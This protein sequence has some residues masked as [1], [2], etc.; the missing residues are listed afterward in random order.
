MRCD[1]PVTILLVLLSM[2]LVAGLVTAQPTARH[3]DVTKATGPITI[4]GRLDEAAWQGALEFDIPYEWNPGDNA[5]A[6][7]ETGVYITYSDEALYVAWRCEDPDPSAIRAHLMDRD[8]IGTFVQDDHV[9]LIIDTFNDERRGFQF[10]VNPLGVQADAFFSENEGIEDFSFDMIWDSV[11]RI[12]ETGYVVEIAIPFDQIRFP[13]SS[14]PQTWGFDVG[15]SYPRNVRHRLSAAPRDRNNG[16]ILCQVDKVSGFTGLEPGRNLEIIPTLTAGRTD[17]LDGFPDGDLVSGDEDYELGVDARWGINPNLTLS[18]AIN[19]DFSQ[20]EADAAQLDVNTRFALFFPERRPFFLEGI[21]VF[22]TPMRAVFTRTVVDP[23]W[24]L[25]LSGKEGPHSFGVFVA[26]DTVNNLLIPANERS[27]F[28]SVDDSV[29]S[30]VL[31]YRRDVGRNSSVGALYAGREGSAY[32]NDVY[33]VDGFFRLSDSDT[34]RFQALRSDTEYPTAVADGLGQSRDGF[35]GEAIFLDYDH[36]SR[37][38]NA[39]LFHQQLSPE[40]RADSGFIPKVDFKVWRAFV[41]RLFWGEEGD[42]HNQWSVGAF[43]ERGE[44]YAGESTDEVSQVFVNL[45][46]PLQSFTE[47]AFSRNAQRFG[48]I[49]HEDMDVFEAFTTLQ[50]TGSLKFSFNSRVGE[51]V[52]VANNQIA[53]EVLLV[54][55]VEWKLGQHINLQVAHNQQRLDVPGGELFEANLTDLRLVYNF[56][57]RSFLRAIVQNL[58]LERDPSLFPGDIEPEERSLFTQLLFSYKLNPR[59]V[60]FLGYSG[61]RL[62]LEGTSLVET[63]RTI[64]FK[65]GYAWTL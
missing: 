6:P 49:F 56:N 43:G 8:D 21:D 61:G 1:R 14:E 15:R 10:R 18:A 26:E 35:T 37:H 39:S 44:N 19:P 2:Q 52:D 63:D 31:R 16:C 60:L 34:F 55:S 48:G 25:K 47:V 13:R 29:T 3:F 45:N 38:W 9:V 54:P 51:T 24:G 58:D 50:P 33:G 36:N 41:Q 11:G 42:W 17:T 32:R 62:G 7:V 27:R 4:D 22:T 65:M 23:D 53:D 46:G 12:H 64:F 20:V 59:T 57:V 5:P 30:G 28:T 40:F